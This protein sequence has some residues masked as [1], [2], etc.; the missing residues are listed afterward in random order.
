MPAVT[1][2][3]SHGGGNELA[4]LNLAWEHCGF[5]VPICPEKKVLS[6]ITPRSL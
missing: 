6:E 5:Q 2:P 3:S 1:Q 4:K